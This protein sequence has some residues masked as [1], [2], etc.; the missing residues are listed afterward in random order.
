MTLFL[1]KVIDR[2]LAVSSQCHLGKRRHGTFSDSDMASVRR[3][4]DIEE[5]LVAP[6]EQIV[7]SDSAL[8]SKR[9]CDTRLSPL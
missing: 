6:S 5:N 4:L 3:Q 7:E 1:F 2:R 9:R 8:P